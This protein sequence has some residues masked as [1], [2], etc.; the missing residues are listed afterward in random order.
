M[1][2][3]ELENLVARLIDRRESA[4]KDSAEWR[5][6]CD[7][8]GKLIEQHPDAAFMAEEYSSNLGADQ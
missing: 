8:I 5:A 1:D 4:A 7:S 2:K 6:A 3:Q